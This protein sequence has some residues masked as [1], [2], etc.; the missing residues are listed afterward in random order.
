MGFRR[1]RLRFGLVRRS[2]C[3]FWSGRF[4]ILPPD[5]RRPPLSAELLDDRKATAEN[6]LGTHGR[7][8]SMTGMG[9]IPRALELGTVQDLR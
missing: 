9:A 7:D 3:G 8:A 2:T 5:Q 4:S 1:P 6:G